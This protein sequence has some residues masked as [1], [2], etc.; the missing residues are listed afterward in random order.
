LAGCFYYFLAFLARF[1][2]PENVAFQFAVTNPAMLRLSCHHLPLTR[3]SYFFL[4]VE[5]PHEN[6]F[7]L[8]VEELVVSG[9]ILYNAL[10]AIDLLNFY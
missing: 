1:T 9:A 6:Q 3:F 2:A 10:S 7:F 4:V 8:N 5:V